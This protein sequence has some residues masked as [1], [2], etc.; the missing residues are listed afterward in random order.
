M[1]PLQD[2][3]PSRTVPYVNYAV[4]ACCALVFLVQLGDQPGKPSMVERFGMIPKRVMQPD[5]RI[6]VQSLEEEQTPS[7]VRQV[8]VTHEAAPSAVPPIM[9]LLTCVFLHGGWMHIIGNM[10]FLFIFGDNVEDRFGH[11]GYAVFY[12]VSGIGASLVHLV[13]EPS[14]MIPTIGASGAIAGVMG[15]YFLWYRHAQV[16]ALVPLGIFIQIMVLPAW[17]FLGFW[18]VIQFL[19][20]TMSITAAESTGVAWWAH[21]GGFAVGFGLAWLAEKWGLVQPLNLQRDNSRAVHYRMQPRHRD[22][23]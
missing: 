15:A 9:T 12:L 20:G 18:F 19:Q 11:V 13:S 17:F 14:S 22:H 10:W 6:E 4:I 1:L 7:G 2:N 23:Y 16:K 3:I 5:A 21:I 8:V